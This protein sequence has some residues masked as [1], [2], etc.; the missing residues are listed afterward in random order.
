MPTSN[1]I[2]AKLILGGILFGAGWGCGGLCPGP[3]VVNLA[4][5]PFNPLYQAFF[6]SM[7]VGMYLESTS[8][9]RSLF[10]RA[11]DKKAA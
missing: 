1:T 7:L 5:F 3:A 6:A 4:A 10:D 11:P 9:V 8:F 2:D